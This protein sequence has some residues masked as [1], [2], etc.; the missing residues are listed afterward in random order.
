[1]R[2]SKKTL[3]RRRIT[4]PTK[5]PVCRGGVGGASR[6]RTSKPVDIGMKGKPKAR[7]E[8]M[9]KAERMMKAAMAASA[10]FVCRSEMT[11]VLRM[12]QKR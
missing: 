8:K 11:G 12:R 7:I 6:S 4:K 1:M 2:A 5:I 3:S 9:K 10:N